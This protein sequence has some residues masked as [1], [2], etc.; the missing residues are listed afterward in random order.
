MTNSSLRTLVALVTAFALLGAALATT[1]GA[2]IP[3]RNCGTM[4]VKGKRWQV[5]A[6]QIR[7]PTAKRYA[8]RYIRHRGAP[9]YYKC[10]R[11]SSGSRIFATCI[12]ARYSP[13]RAFQI[14]RR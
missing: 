13:D 7:C 10:R 5:K 2:I 12:A 11:G 1:A 4:T 6:D 8:T 14:I 3:P 9:R